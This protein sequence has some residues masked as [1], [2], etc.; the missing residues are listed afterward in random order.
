[1]N[2]SYSVQHISNITPQSHYALET[3]HEWLTQYVVATPLKLLTNQDMEWLIILSE[4]LRK[5]WHNVAIR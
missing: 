5:K 3:V 1:M 2:S 4:W